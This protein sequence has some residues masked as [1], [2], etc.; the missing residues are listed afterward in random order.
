MIAKCFSDLLMYPYQTLCP[1]AVNLWKKKTKK[2]KFVPF[3]RC[4]VESVYTSEFDL[5]K[6][7]I[8]F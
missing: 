5:I 3:G 6:K 4:D 7:D 2:L 1:G 8:L